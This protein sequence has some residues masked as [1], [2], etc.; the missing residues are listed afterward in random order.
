MEYLNIYANCRIVKGAGMSLLYDLQL[1]R[2]YHIPND[3]ADVYLFLQQ[4]SIEECV[5]HY[6][7]DNRETIEDYIDFVISRE[8]GFK[9]QQLLP[10]LTTLDLSWDRYADITNVI[11]EYNEAIDYD[12]P[13]FRELFALHVQALEIRYYHAVT[14]DKIR[15]FVERFNG[16]T[17]KYIKL[18]LSYDKVLDLQLLDKLVKQYPRVKSLLIHSSPV[19]RQEK[20]FDGSVPV[21]FFDKPI[22]SCMACGEIRANYFVSNLELFTES[23]HYN[24]CLNRKLSINLNGYI[25]NC[26]SMQEDYGHVATASLRQVLD[27]PVF[28]RY[29]SIRKDDITVC[30][31]CEFRHAC[32][33]CRAY[34]ENPEDVY[35]KPLKCGYDPYTNKWEDWTQHPMK[36]AAIACYGL[37]ETNN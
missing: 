3:T 32:T 36:Q 9:D 4:H 26:P 11:I 20:I 8:L 34:V 22:N 33:D 16:T 19:L 30:R 5:A 18:V 21:V 29:G 35:S 1:R 14:L 17:L 24:T 7:E 27:N 6:G 15:A 13:F 2:Y 37:K 10:E 23:Q 28:R 25:K 31:D 12:G